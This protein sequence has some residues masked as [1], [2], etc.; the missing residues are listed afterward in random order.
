MLGINVTKALGL[1][2]ADDVST[3]PIRCAVAH[4]DAKSGVLN[5]RQIIF[6]TGP[7]LGVGSGTIDLEHERMAFRI[8]G[9]PKELRLVRVLAP[10]TLEGPIVKPKVGVETGKA[11]AQGGIAAALGA[12]ISPLAAILPFI[13]PGLAKDAAC[14]ALVAEARREGAPVKAAQ[15]QA[16]AR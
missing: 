9:K 16:A 8:Q 5:A 7:V 14:G 3:T 1:L 11:I 12:L 2:L 10:I 15:R 6:D 4:F 13:D